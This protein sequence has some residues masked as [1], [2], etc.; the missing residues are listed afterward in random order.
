MNKPKIGSKIK[1]WF[2]ADGFSTVLKVKKYE[3][4]YPQWFKWTVTLSAPRT[5]AREIDMAI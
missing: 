1:T 3:G 5:F 4:V 2:S